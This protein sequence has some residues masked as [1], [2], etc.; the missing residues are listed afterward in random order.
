[1]SSLKITFWCFLFFKGSLGEAECYR[2]EGVSFLSEVPLFYLFLSIRTLTS[3][4]VTIR[5]FFFC[6]LLLCATLFLLWGC[7][8]KLWDAGTQMFHFFICTL[9]L[10]ERWRRWHHRWVFPP[11]CH[12]SAC[13]LRPHRRVFRFPHTDVT[14]VLSSKLNIPL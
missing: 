2:E 12:G 9:K 7:S 10:I 14:A 5:E 6:L 1:M 8:T 11:P 3:W 13:Q 4:A